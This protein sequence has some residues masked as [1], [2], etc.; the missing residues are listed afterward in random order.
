[1]GLCPAAAEEALDGVHDGTNAGRSCWV[2]AGTL[3]KDSVQGH[4][5]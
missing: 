3:C 1:M 5:P 2:V 4:L